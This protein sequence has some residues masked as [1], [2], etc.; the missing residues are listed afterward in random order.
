VAQ[1]GKSGSASAARRERI[2]EAALSA[3][4]ELGYGATS[5][6]EVVARA[7]GSKATLY[8]Y[9][10]SKEDLF[11]TVVDT[12]VQHSFATEL[13]AEEP[14]D[15]A[16]VDYA[17]Q[18]LRVALADKHNALRRLVIGEGARFPKIAETYYAHGPERS[19][20]QLE[21]YFRAETA[22]GRLAIE[23]PGTAAEVFRGM[24]MHSPYLRTLFRPGRRIPR[25]EL[26]RHARKVVG[27]FLRL[28][29]P[30]AGAGE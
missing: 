4:L 12:L 13:A 17:Q 29:P 19:H 20:K 1:R 5:M 8:K 14:P 2:I 16:L 18:R 26:E 3:F 25:A 23:D 24:L 11:T 21:A 30:G 15:K 7:G 6:D 22:R 27:L 9:F 28:Y 10:S